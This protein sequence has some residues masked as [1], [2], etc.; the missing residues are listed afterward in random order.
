MTDEM[1]AK[2]GYPTKEDREADRLFLRLEDAQG[3]S[4]HFLPEGIVFEPKLFEQFLNKA[5]AEHA[6]SIAKGEVK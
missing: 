3:V 6:S 5:I 4:H 2:V 1:K